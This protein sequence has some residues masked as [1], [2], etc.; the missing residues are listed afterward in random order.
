[1]TSQEKMQ[2]MSKRM[3]VKSGSSIA[4]AE[5]PGDGLYYDEFTGIFFKSNKSLILAAELA[6]NHELHT[7]GIVWANTYYNILGID[8]DLPR[9]GWS[10]EITNWVDFDHTFMDRED[11][12]YHIIVPIPFPEAL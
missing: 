5:G 12:V 11:P 3:L 1:M 4:F 10:T 7:I 9:Y 8:I 2:I 6:I